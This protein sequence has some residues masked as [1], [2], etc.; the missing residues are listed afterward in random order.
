MF[1]LNAVELLGLVAAV[2]VA[3]SLSL[4]NPVKLRAINGVGAVMW[5][6][7][8]SLIGST[9]VVLLNVWI[10]IADVWHLRKL[11]SNESSSSS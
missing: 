1:E 4:S 6:V 10:F 11:L 9:S 2:V 3:V 8:G 5:V 7:Y